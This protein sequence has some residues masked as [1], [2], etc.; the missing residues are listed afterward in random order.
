MEQVNDDVKTVE[1]IVESAKEISVVTTSADPEPVTSE[2]VYGPTYI[3]GL[4]GGALPSDFGLTTGI[5]CS[6]IGVICIIIHIIKF[7][8]SKFY[9]LSFREIL[10]LGI[11]IA[12][13][14]AGV[15]S[16]LFW[17]S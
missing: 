14:V 1:E 12:N 4:S 6:V 11:G 3:K 13:L 16:F 9:H 2:T 17:L 10:P 15:L 5:L 8:K 7:R